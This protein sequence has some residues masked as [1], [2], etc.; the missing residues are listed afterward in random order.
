MPIN[1]NQMPI[2]DTPQMPSK[3]NILQK[4][5]YVKREWMPDNYKKLYNGDPI[6]FSRGLKAATELAKGAFP[7]DRENLDYTKWRNYNTFMRNGRTYFDPRYNGIY[8]HKDN[9]EIMRV[10]ESTP[11]SDLVDFNRY[12]VVRNYNPLFENEIG[13]ARSNFHPDGDENPI[14]YY[15]ADPRNTIVQQEAR[16]NGLELPQE[17]ADQITAK[18]MLDGFVQMLHG[19]GVEDGDLKAMGIKGGYKGIDLNIFDYLNKHRYDSDFFT[20]KVLKVYRSFLGGVENQPLEKDQRLQKQLLNDMLKIGSFA[21]DHGSDS[22]YVFV[23]PDNEGNM[24]LNVP[25]TYANGGRLSTRKD[26]LFSPS[27]IF[28]DGGKMKQR[29]SEP[30]PETVDYFSRH[31]GTPMTIGELNRM[32]EQYYAEQD[33]KARQEKEMRDFVIKQ[34][35]KYFKKQEEDRLRMTEEARNRW[36]NGQPSTDTSD[37]TEEQPAETG[38]S[39]SWW[40][41]PLSPE[42]LK[43]AYNPNPKQKNESVTTQPRTAQNSEASGKSNNQVANTNDEID[44]LALDVIR[45]KY[46]NGKQRREALGDL[47]SVVQKRANEMLKGKRSNEDSSTRERQVAD[48]YRKAWDETPEEY[49]QPLNSKTF[50]PRRIFNPRTYDLTT[51]DLRLHERAAQQARQSRSLDDDPHSLIRDN[52]EVKRRIGGTN[53][54]DIYL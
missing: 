51:D 16:E 20:N 1:N 7:Y 47:Y 40:L 24:N 23:A 11:P 52:G 53:N 29:R 26:N 32:R 13:V 34:R 39:K 15:R 9:G 43:I 33:E 45:G 4:G 48:A 3:D 14:P 25:N 44:K 38:S 42:W 12:S 22:P 50:D 30:S 41:N 49:K 19:Y 2:N 28:A 10:D 6:T 5:I 21:R 8:G 27:H 18:R 35:E 54:Y 17:T 31:A 36:F 46:G 37:K